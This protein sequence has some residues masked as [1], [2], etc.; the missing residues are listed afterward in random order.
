MCERACLLK[1]TALT[2]GHIVLLCSAKEGH[3]PPRRTVSPLAVQNA[4]IWPGTFR[5]LAILILTTAPPALLVNRD[6]L[7]GDRLSFSGNSIKVSWLSESPAPPLAVKQRRPCEASFNNHSD[8]DFSL[9]FPLQ[10]GKKNTPCQR[11]RYGEGSYNEI[12]F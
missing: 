2:L 12:V 3:C 1:G 11:R 9:F 8:I 5:P 7:R 6:R 10:K 4:T